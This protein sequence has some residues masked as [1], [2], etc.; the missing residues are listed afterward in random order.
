MPLTCRKGIVD[1]GQRGRLRCPSLSGQATDL[2][3]QI[4]NFNVDA[5]C[6]IAYTGWPSD[7]EKERT[8]EPY[9]YCLDAVRSRIWMIIARMS[10]SRRTDPPGQ[11]VLTV[12]RS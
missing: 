2:L 4:S 6:K 3:T 1:A 8:Y 12:A 9:C 10:R 11:A 7:P 5:R